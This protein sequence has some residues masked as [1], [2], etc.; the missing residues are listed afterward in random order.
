MSQPD[1]GRPPQTEMPIAVGGEEFVQQGGYSHP[2]HLGQQQRDVIHPFIGHCWFLAHIRSSP[3][4]SKLVN[5]SEP[6][7]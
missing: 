2:F 6:W 5:L 1:C 7:G 3:Q 4:F